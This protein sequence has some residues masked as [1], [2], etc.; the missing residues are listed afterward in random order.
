MF[1][2]KILENTEAAERRMNHHPGKHRFETI[3]I[4]EFLP[5]RLRKLPSHF[6]PLPLTSRKS[7][8]TATRGCSVT[9]LTLFL[10][11]DIRII[12][13]NNAATVISGHNAFSVV[14]SVPQN[15]VLEEESS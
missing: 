3:R 15:G 8:L 7:L 13:L 4:L 14:E 12:L 1:I 11:L 10:L 5:D 6:A 2:I 9:H